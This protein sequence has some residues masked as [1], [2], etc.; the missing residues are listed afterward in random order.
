MSISEQNT[1]KMAQAIFEV[2]EGRNILLTFVIYGSKYN[3]YLREI[4]C[5]EPFWH[6]LNWL[7]C[8]NCV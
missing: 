5:A 8:I 6:V 7:K 4:Q 3:N 2:L 1:F